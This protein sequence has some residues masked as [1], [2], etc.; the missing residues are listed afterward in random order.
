MTWVVPALTCLGAGALI[1][2]GAAAAAEPTPSRPNVVLIVSDDQTMDS[3]AA[4][5]FLT[6]KPGGH[7][8]E[9]TNAFENTPWC[10]PTRATLLSGLYSH[11][12]GVVESNGA[13]FD[14][15]S[16]VATWLQSAGYRTGLTG[17]YLNDYPYGQPPYTP[18]GWSDWFANVD[19]SQH[20]NYY[21]NDNGNLVFYGNLPTDY[22]T[23]VVARRAESFIHSS[24]GEPF[25]LY[26]APVAPHSPLQP[27]VR[28]ATTPVTVT[29]PPNF[30][31]LDVSDK[32]AWIQQTPLLSNKDAGQQDKNR[33]KSFRMV[34]AVDDLVRT[35][36]QALLDT[37]QL[38][39]TVII[40]MTDNGYLFGE[41]RQTEKTCI[42]EEC[43]RTPMFMRVPWLPQR[44][45]P[46]LFSSV[47]IAPTV[48]ELAGI[49]PQAPVDGLSAVSLLYDASTPWRSGLLTEFAGTTDRPRFWSIRTADWKY[50]EL[51]TGERE[52]YDMANDR[53]E[54]ENR[55]G[56]P[57]LADLQASLSAELEALRTAPPHQILPS[58]SIADAS[59]TEG[60]NASFTL[61]LSVASSATTTV[62]AST[63][64]GTATA[65]D[66]YEA[67]SDVVTFAPGLQSAT[68]TVPVA[69][70][71]IAEIDETFSVT[72]SDPSGLAILDGHAVGSIDDA[73]EV[74][75]ISVSDASVVEGN[76]G[77]T[78]LSF[79]ITLSPAR[80]EPVSV[81]YETSDD[82]AVA[83]DDYLGASGVVTFDPGETAKTV[84][85]G[86]VGDDV[87][88]PDETFVLQLSAPE[89]AALADAVGV[90]TIVDDDT[91]PPASVASIGDAIVAEGNAGT[92][93]AS[94]TVSLSPPA[95]GHV[96]VSWQTADGSASPSDYQPASGIVSFEAGESAKAIAVGVLGDTTHEA[97]E[98][99][100]VEIAS[101]DVEVADPRGIGTITND[102]APPSITISDVSLVEGTGGTSTAVFVA[103]LSAPS[104]LPATVD[105]FT[106]DGSAKAPADYQ[107]ASGTLT[108]AAGQISATI[109]V[110]VVGDSL[111]E[112]AETFTLNLANPVGATIAD[113]SGR[114][115]INNDDFAAGTTAFG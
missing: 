79:A 109:S 27:P 14:E 13:P 25:F 101:N 17:K 56:D 29:R 12:H 20:Y 5:P 11:H 49:V 82:S 107:S 15:S 30:N 58:V 40:F 91:P 3:L 97:N 72:L 113:P 81:S 52:L 22:Q 106:L 103:S 16:T 55:A 9:F 4:M 8:I 23:D 38:E 64:D 90:G 86:V 21:M 77:S 65:P 41:H 44:T 89:G 47:D 28:Y 105:F 114:C 1:S 80:A 66:D 42:Y 43:I 6:S 76:A 60:S 35:V 57:A 69:A 7:W 92:S 67:R 50:A 115:L 2:A 99:F 54:L 63:A 84:E 110:T 75:T 36:Y 19:R 88:E 112:R 68:F 94:F 39:N 95:A 59:A 31:E 96:E 104:G 62:R 37:G 73:G 61:T 71:A 10:C 74:S 34:M 32:P 53:Y 100:S 70:D 33:A 48:A 78:P 18:P 87:P 26:A 45:E 46:E 85:V 108:F 102:D 24:A 98:S 51:A 83:P 93:S 111:S